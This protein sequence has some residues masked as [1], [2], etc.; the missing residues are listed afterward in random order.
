MQGQQKYKVGQSEIVNKKNLEG[1]GLLPM[2]SKT[3]KISVG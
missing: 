1:Y 3:A 2:V